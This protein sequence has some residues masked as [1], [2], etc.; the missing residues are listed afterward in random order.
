MPDDLRFVEQLHRD[1]LAVRWPEPA[2]IR[3]RAG[4]RSRRTAVLAAV[5]VLVVASASAVAVAARPGPPPASPPVTAIAGPSPSGW[6]PAEVPLEVL[7][8]P[9][10]VRTTSEALTQAGLGEKVSVD[11]L[12]LYCHHA[13][14]LTADWEPSRYS[15]SVTLVRRSAGAKP[16]FVLSEDVYR[17]A[18]EVGGRLFAGID[19]ML[20]PCGNWRSRGP[21]TRQGEVID[22]E[23]IHRWE[24]VDRNFAGAESA[25]L[26]HSVSKPR[27]LTTGR[28]FGSPSSPAGT[29]VVRVGDL[30]AVINMG[31]GGTEPELRR[32][33]GV[34][35]DRMCPAANPPC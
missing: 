14:R 22:A 10:D 32:L 35:A 20:A 25:L 16:E 19:K 4:R 8:G 29:A 30:V 34:A 11:E 6:V 7:L 3:A 26:R 1:L 15:R 18:P 28:T 31:R 27:N 12:L 23:A 13:Q 5:A 33:A 17:V 2:E 21:V 9:A 24:V